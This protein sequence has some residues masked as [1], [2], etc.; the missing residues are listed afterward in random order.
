MS[1]AQERLGEDTKKWRRVARE[2][3][4]ELWATM[5]GPGPSRSDFY[6]ADASW[7]CDVE[8]NWDDVADYADVPLNELQGSQ[9][10][11]GSIGSIGSML[12]ELRVAKILGW[13]EET[14]SFRD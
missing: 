4:W 3:A 7:D 5:D 9:R 8:G 10:S 1:K 6:D 14:Q 13:D 2:V 12:R 11:I